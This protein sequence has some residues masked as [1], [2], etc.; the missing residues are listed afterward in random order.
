MFRPGGVS[1]VRTLGLGRGSLVGF[2]PAILHMRGHSLKNANAM[3]LRVIE[4]LFLF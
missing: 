4:A 3:F 2:L 1:L